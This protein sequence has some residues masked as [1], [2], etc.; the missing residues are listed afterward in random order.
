MMILW[1]VPICTDHVFGAIKTIILP[2]CNCT[3]STGVK[4]T[5]ATNSQLPASC[6]W[7]L[8]E[9]AAAAAAAALWNDHRHHCTPLPATICKLFQFYLVP[10]P[11]LPTWQVNLI[12]AP[13]SPPLPLFA[14]L[15][16]LHNTSSSPFLKVLPNFW[17]LFFPNTPHF[18]VSISHALLLRATFSDI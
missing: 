15:L 13:S 11:Y 2:G 10:P 8:S 17:D 18:L 1:D 5:T 3:S 12:S 6:S 16:F 9:P 7:Y 4:Y 14:C